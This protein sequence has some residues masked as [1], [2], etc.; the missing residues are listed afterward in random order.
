MHSGGSRSRSRSRN[1]SSPSSI[2]VGAKSGLVSVTDALGARAGEA[3]LQSD[4]LALLGLIIESKHLDSSEKRFGH[5]PVME[6]IVTTVLDATPYCKISEEER[7]DP[8]FQPKINKTL[9]FATKP[10]V[11]TLSKVKEYNRNP[12]GLT[13]SQ[14]AFIEDMAES[15]DLVPRVARILLAV[16]ALLFYSLMQSFVGWLPAYFKLKEFPGSTQDWTF[17]GSQ[18]VS[19]Y[20]FFMFAGCL[21]SI[22]CSVYISPTK[23][24]RFHLTLILTGSVLLQFAVAAVPSPLVTLLLLGSALMGYGI[25][26]LFPLI[27]TVA[28]DYGF[29][30]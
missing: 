2:S 13:A 16:M 4:E 6:D 30:M 11:D 7:N 21:A 8:F 1:S 9:A 14:I 5:A 28:G 26:A 23:L 19:V 17:M 12:S 20:F 18:M 15:I 25:S 29:T 3:R 27:V 10:I 22:P 24:L